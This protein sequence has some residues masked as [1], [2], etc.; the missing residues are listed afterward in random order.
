[1]KE[2]IMRYYHRQ[3]ALNIV[4]FSAVCSAFLLFFAP[5]LRA[6]QSRNP[7][8][9]AMER[10]RQRQLR[11]NARIES[12]LMIT[13]LEKEGKRPVVEEHPRLAYVQIK[14]D[15]GRLQTVHNQMMVMTFSNN[16]LDYKRISEASSEIKKRAARLMSNLPLPESEG[17]AQTQSPL[18]GLDELDRGE[19]KPALLS[20]DELVMRFV[21]N[22]VFQSPE[23]VDVQQSAKARND[24]EA[25]IKLSAKIK[26][27]TERWLKTASA[28]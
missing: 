2:L 25:I 11:Q 16:V 6:Q 12:N 26:K 27:S 21:N 24:L 13:T 3:R 14:E 8:E 5:A 7:A 23:I 4:V 19:V 17:G 10:Q 15:F 20:L 9:A 22:P 1:M 28:K 18:K